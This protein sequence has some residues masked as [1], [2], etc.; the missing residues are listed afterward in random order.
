MIMSSKRFGRAAHLHA[1]VRRSRA[2]PH[3]PLSSCKPRQ[4]SR[5]ASARFL[6]IFY[7]RE[8]RSAT[9]MENGT[10]SSFTYSCGTEALPYDQLLQANLTLYV[11]AGIRCR[12]LQVNSWRLSHT[13]HRRKYKEA[14]RQTH[15]RRKSFYPNQTI[16]HASSARLRPL[17][18]LQPNSRKQGA[19]HKNKINTGDFAH[20]TFRTNH[21]LKWKVRAYVEGARIHPS[22]AKDVKR[23]N[24]NFLERCTFEVR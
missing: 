16:A 6:F 2:P 3:L 23:G 19:T 22:T 5:R 10:D 21:A 1:Y 14:K 9:I 17:P 8:A 11:C 20:F 4:A 15:R 24:E 18:P 7:L 13:C 12:T